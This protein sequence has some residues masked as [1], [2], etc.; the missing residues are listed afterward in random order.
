MTDPFT[1]PVPSV[2]SALNNECERLARARANLAAAETAVT[3]ALEALGD[4]EVEVSRF[5]RH[6]ELIQR[7]VNGL[8]DERI[9]SVA[10]QAEKVAAG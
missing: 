10:Q 3:A 7:N 5:T 6:I 9:R 1:R 2:D 8:L 4:A